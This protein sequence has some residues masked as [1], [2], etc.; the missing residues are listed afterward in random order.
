[1]KI[2]IQSDKE[3]ESYGTYDAIKKVFLSLYGC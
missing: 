1:M 2:D 3:K